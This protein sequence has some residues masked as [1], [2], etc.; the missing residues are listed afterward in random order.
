VSAPAI[1]GTGAAVALTPL[2]P[3]AGSRRRLR[4][5]A[6]NGWSPAELARRL[7]GPAHLVRMLL[8]GHSQLVAEDLASRIAA[9]YDDLWDQQGPSWR[10]AEAARRHSFAPALA[11]DDDRP[12]DPWYS[13]HGIDDPDATPAPGWQRHPVRTRLT[14]DEQAAE[15]AD[16]VRLGLSLN[17]AAIRLRI[18]GAALT[19]IRDRMQF[20]S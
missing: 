11:W 15:L 20:A 1:T 10:T 4:A 19:R 17:Q 6:W 7:D 16:L 8:R 13:G 12:G 18:S 14:P 3:V 5:L 9:L 2:V